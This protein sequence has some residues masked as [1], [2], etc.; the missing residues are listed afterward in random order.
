MGT[1][2]FLRVSCGVT[3][4]LAAQAAAAADADP[5]RPVNTVNPS[6]AAAT[7]QNDPE[8]PVPGQTKVEERDIVVTGTRAAAILDQPVP[9]SLITAEDRNLAGVGDA[10]QL[11]DVQPGF[12][13]NDTYGLSVRGVGR[14][15]PQTLL[16]QENAVV[17]YTDGFINL[18]PS[19]ISESTL[20]GG[21]VIFQRGPAGTLYGRNALAGSINIVSRAPTKTWTAEFEAGY[22]RRNWYDI[23]ANIAGPLTD[24]LGIRIGAQ[25]FN[26]P[27]LQNNLGSARGAGFAQDNEYFEFQVE[28]RFRGFHVRN[29]A[30]HF[31]YDNQPGYPSLSRYSTTTLFGGLS[32]NPQFGYA[33]PVPSKPY[34]INVDYKGYDRLRNNFQDVLN[35]DLDLGFANLV[36]VGGY[37]KYTATG[38]SDRDLTSRSSYSADALAPGSFV[39]GTIVPT[40]YRNGYDNHNSFWSQEARLESKGGG[41][42]NWVAGYYH[43]S[44]DFN[45]H[46]YQTIP[47]AGTILTTPTVGGGPALAAPNP[48]KA[49][50]EQRN[51]FHIRSDAVFGNATWDFTPTLRF[52]GGLRYTWDHKDAL[53]NFRYVFY[54][55]PAF[56][57]D[58]TP[59]IHSASP[60]RDDRGLSGH[61]TLAWRPDAGKQ[62]YISYQ[63]GY[64]SSAFTLGQGLPPNNIARSE[65]LD[66]YEVGGSYRVRNLRFDGSL[67]YQNF[68]NE[69]IPISTRSFVNGAFTPVFQQF[70]NAKRAEIYGAEVQASW[71]PNDHSNIIASYTYLHPTFKDFCPALVGVVPA[72]CGAIDITGS[73]LPQNLAGNE[74][75]RTPRNKVTL[76]GYYG[77]SLGSLGYLY[78]GG[79]L[80]YQSSFRSSPFRDDRFHFGAR[81]LVGLTLT[82]RTHNE[83]FD[84][85]GAVSNVFDKVYVDDSVISGV[86]SNL[87]SSN[88]LGAPRFYNVVARYRF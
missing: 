32:P 80:S 55:P 43:F 61:A 34:Q 79:S 1:R 12:F 18:V 4:L 67:F 24:N 77:V 44:Q 11:V 62:L 88:T 21:N 37:Q 22:G 17:Q 74:I 15:T 19:N 85:T 46:F 3:A 58:F 50:F 9:V 82:Y 49:E 29:R 2:E 26:A 72:T 36:Y 53:T 14:Q 10:R 7:H 81:T 47:G 48:L 33:G 84:I 8:T 38:A 87:F 65:H 23:G 86:T 59:A 27:T 16:G 20:F 56:A 64:Q 69:Q 41:T 60:D 5:P 75:P 70:V 42:F 25:K 57:G 51:I 63:R 71:Q 76:Y 78:P 39:P 30:T 52:D 68:F 73:P 83:K 13:F 35:A 6:A 66:V 45:E 40:D 28:W 54:Y 31:Q